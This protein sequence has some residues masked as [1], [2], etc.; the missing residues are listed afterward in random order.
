[1]GLHTKNKEGS[2]KETVVYLV[3][4]VFFVFNHVTK[5]CHVTRV[6]HAVDIHIVNVASADM[7]SSANVVFSEY[8]AGLTGPAKT[9]Y[10]EKVFTCGF[11]SYRVKKNRSVAS[12]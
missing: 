6:R 5:F 1:M 2:I 8:Y 12:I 9:R 10:N 4:F 11:D 7:R 3:C